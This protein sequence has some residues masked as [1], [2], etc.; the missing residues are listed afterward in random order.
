[1]N[2]VIIGVG[3]N[4][5]PEGNIAKARDRIA[6]QHR[7]IAE[8]AFV[9]TEPIGFT[10]QPNFLNGVFHIETEF[11]YPS[12]KEWLLDTEKALG[13]RRGKNKYGPR[14]IDLDIVVWNGKIVDD[15][16]HKRKFLRNAVL[17]VWPELEK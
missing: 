9:E 11:D 4:I 1:M 3:S 17:E 6:S 12:L 10:D 5:L 7:L 2:H 13:R 16:F 14:T 8:S 15:D